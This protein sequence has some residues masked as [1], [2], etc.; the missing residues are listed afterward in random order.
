MVNQDA[1]GLPKSIRGNIEALVTR[2]VVIEAFRLAR[3]APKDIDAAREKIISTTCFHY[4]MLE[5]SNKSGLGLRTPESNKIERSIK[6]GQRLIK[7]T[8][9]WLHDSEEFEIPGRITDQLERITHRAWQYESILADTQVRLILLQAGLESLSKLPP[10]TG[11]LTNKNH[12]SKLITRLATIWE[13]ETG[14]KATAA[15]PR[16]E[17]D[18]LFVRFCKPIVAALEPEYSLKTETI[19]YWLNSSSRSPG[20][21]P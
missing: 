6:R 20:A 21:N 8:L 2:D 16:D 12:L 14:S 1:D 3:P 4:S 10:A 7:E 9:A 11:P 19:K 18:S 5:Q 17:S 15:S 13:D